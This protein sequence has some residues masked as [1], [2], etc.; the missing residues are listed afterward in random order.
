MPLITKATE[1][2][3]S[4]LTEDETVKHFPKEFVV[5]SVQWIWWLS[6]R[7]DTPGFMP[8]QRACLRTDIQ[9]T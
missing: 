3:L 7:G 2:I 4:I 5:A 9:T 6:C 8:S 1:Y